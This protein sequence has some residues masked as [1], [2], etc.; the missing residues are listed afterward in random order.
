MQ[1]PLDKIRLDLYKTNST[2]TGRERPEKGKLF[3]MDWVIVGDCSRWDLGE[4]GLLAG[5]N[6]AVWGRGGRRDCGRRL[7]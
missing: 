2:G 5:R 3:M 4:L 1:L 7:F 6:G